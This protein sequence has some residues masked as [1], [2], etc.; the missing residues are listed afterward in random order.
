MAQEPW[1]TAQPGIDGTSGTL[2][3]GARRVSWGFAAP[4]QNTSRQGKAAKP[5][6]GGCAHN[7]RYT[8]G[9]ALAAPY[10]PTFG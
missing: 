2:T 3:A 6:A 5:H 10:C 8:R 7:T 9:A 4:T 1:R